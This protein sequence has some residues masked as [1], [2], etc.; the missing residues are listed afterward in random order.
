MNNLLC[1]VNCSISICRNALYILDKVVPVVYHSRTMVEKTCKGCGNVFYIYP[2]RLKRTVSFFCSFSCRKGV[3]IAKKLM[4]EVKCIQCKTRTVRLRSGRDVR[5]CSSKC[6]GLYRKGAFILKKGYKR[7]LYPSHHRADSKGYVREHILVME[8]KIGR[9]I[10]IGEV[11]HHIDGNK[12]NN[13][14]DNLELI[15]SQS[16]HMRHHRRSTRI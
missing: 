9:K 7:V 4:P 10:T 11:V 16:E 5:F 8:T 13:S 15:W 1:L 12:M 14:A 2:Y 6:F 3:L